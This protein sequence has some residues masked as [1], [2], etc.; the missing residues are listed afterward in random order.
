MSIFEFAHRSPMLALSDCWISLEDVA[1]VPFRI[2]TQEGRI[3]HRNATPYIRNCK[4]L[5]ALF[6]FVYFYIG[7]WR[8]TDL[9]TLDLGMI[10]TCHLCLGFKRLEW[11]RFFL[12]LALLPFH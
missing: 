2:R 3:V 4:S 11:N 9:P 5:V 8:S 7:V 6:L 1:A 12:A 10:F